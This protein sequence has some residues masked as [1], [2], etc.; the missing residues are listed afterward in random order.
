MGLTTNDQLNLIKDILKTHHL[1]GAASSNEY[2]QL[3]RV[4]QTLMNNTDF[5]ANSD[6][7][8]A[9]SDYSAKGMALSGYDEHLS[10]NKDNLNSWIQTLS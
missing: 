10:E 9:I 8:Q 3:Y 7:L 2:Q 1:D 4:A 5:N 6:T